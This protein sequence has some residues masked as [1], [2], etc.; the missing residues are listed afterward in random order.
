MEWYICLFILVM[1]LSFLD[2]SKLDICYKQCVM[3][4]LSFI[5]LILASIRWKTGTDW[6]MY[7]D[8]YNNN[9]S[10]Y[11]FLSVSDNV[12]AQEVGFCLLN[13]AVKSIFD[14]YNM[15]LFII[16]LI[17]LVVKYDWYNRYMPF[18]LV[19]LFVNFSSYLGDIFFIRQ[20][21]AIAITIFAFRYIVRKQ[22][23]L[24][25]SFVLIAG[26]M[27]TSAII[28]IPA[29]WIY[30]LQITAKKIVL[31]VA[32]CIGI[33]AFKLTALAISAFMD[34]FPSDMGK[35]VQK[36]W[37][38]Y[39]L[40]Q[41]G[42]NFG[43]VMDGSARIMLAYLRRIF[44]IP[45]YLYFLPYISQH[46]AYYRGCLNLVVFGHILFF[47]TGI[48]GMD[49]A[50]RL[51]IF[52]YIYEVLLITCLMILCKSLRSKFI[53][54]ILLSIYGFLK[55]WYVFYNLGSAYIPYSHIFEIL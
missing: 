37:E 33:D 42:E 3:L 38:Y 27:H 39:L 31:L 17:I 47:L 52:Y 13:W 34:F 9:N 6:V 53:F 44:L 40:E 43:N 4:F 28:F 22:F 24:F 55:Y 26:S 23:W 48:L 50:G 20:S 1:I 51:A 10:L 12:Q 54:Y 32:I 41:S 16:A 19:A 18:P 25:I 30:H 29:Y 35:I 46:N 36:I 11:D 15:L 49:F 21:L 45:I 2:F 7:Y 8:L 14:D 5:F